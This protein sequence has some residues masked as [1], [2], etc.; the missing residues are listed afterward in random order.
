MADSFV[1]L[2]GSTNGLGIKVTGTSGAASVDVH[3]A[4]ASA[5]DLVTL[6]AVN[7]DADSEVRTLH[8]GWGGETDPDNIITVPVPPKAGPVLVADRLPVTGSVVIT[9]WADEAN[10][11]MIYGHVARTGA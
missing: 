1:K 5:L 3:T 9:A 10:D 4:H 2:S 7:Q 11:V 8:L 6:F